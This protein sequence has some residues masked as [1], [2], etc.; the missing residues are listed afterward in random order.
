MTQKPRQSATIIRFPCIDPS[1][2]CGP[3]DSHGMLAGEETHYHHP[4]LLGKI[5]NVLGIMGFLLGSAKMGHGPQAQITWPLP[6]LVA[7]VMECQ[8]PFPGRQTCPGLPKVIPSTG[9]RFS[10]PNG[11]IL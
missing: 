9:R 8:R 1:L 10:G 5:L 7:S 3:G 4:S 6:P 11:H 2:G